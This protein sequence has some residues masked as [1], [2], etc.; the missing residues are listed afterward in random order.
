MNEQG[1]IKIKG[2]ASELLYA[3]NTELK[4]EN[5]IAKFYEESNY[6][7]CL[8]VEEVKVPTQV[9]G[10]EIKQPFNFPNQTESPSVNSLKKIDKDF[11]GNYRWQVVSVGRKP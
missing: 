9:L 10:E 4:E 3:I 2:I 1:V 8:D 6:S 5:E 7:K 11:F